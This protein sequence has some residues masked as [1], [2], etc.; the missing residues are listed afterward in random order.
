MRHLTRLFM[1]FKAVNITGI[2]ARWQP[3]E[4]PAVGSMRSSTCS[5]FRIAL[6]RISRGL[7]VLLHFFQMRLP[8]ILK[9]YDDHKFFLSCCITYP[10]NPFDMPG[11]CSQIVLWRFSSSTNPSSRQHTGGARQPRES[12]NASVAT[13]PSGR[14]ALPWAV[15]KE[16][17]YRKCMIPYHQPVVSCCISSAKVEFTFPVPSLATTTGEAS[18]VFSLHGTSTFCMSLL[19]MTCQIHATAE[20]P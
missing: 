17:R 13:E 20:G 6:T 9:Q 5:C 10:Y 16:V 8:V 15:S 11:R 2:S 12:S 7:R 4:A 18:K 14:W 19:K 3:T 1:S